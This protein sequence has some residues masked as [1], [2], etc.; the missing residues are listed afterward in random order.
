MNNLD[1]LKVYSFDNKIRL[2]QSGDG[3]YIIGD[4]GEKPYDLYISAGVGSEESFTR[5]FIRR[6]KTDKSN[7][8]AF[9][10]TIADFPYHFT[11]DITFIRKNINSFNDDSNTDLGFLTEKYNNIFLKMD[12][13]GG[14]YA[15][16]LNTDSSI[17]NKI[18]QIA[19][20]FHG[21][22]ET[23]HSFH[24]TYDEKVACLEKLN[25]THYLIHAHGNNCC[26]DVKNGIPMIIELTYV[27]K[28]LFLKE[29]LL[30]KI[31]LPIPNLDCP[32]N[33]RPGTDYNLNF[34]PFVS[35]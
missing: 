24:S 27:N 19:I 7:S 25:K 17:L 4:L 28:N 18:K 16:I 21:I 22:T 12:I 3:G 34:Y 20:E 1:L 10:G 33:S 23:G 31:P 6:Y 8:Y 32:N 29:P 13:E 14:E 2:G 11:N 15:W 9:D 30:N 35:A 5:D 26:P